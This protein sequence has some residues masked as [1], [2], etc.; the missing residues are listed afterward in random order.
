VQAAT[1]IVLFPEPRVAN[2][3]ATTLGANQQLLRGAS[4]RPA[5]AGLKRAVRVQAIAS[6]PRVAV[7]SNN[8][9][10][11]ETTQGDWSPESWRKR[12]AHQVR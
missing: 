12:T 3:M 2:T 8:G 6:E 11:P 10:A 1:K 7:T 5:R 4:C 9:A